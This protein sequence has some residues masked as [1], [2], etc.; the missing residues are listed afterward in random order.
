MR[1]FSCGKVIGDKWNAYLELLSRD[2]SEG[3]VIRRAALFRDFELILIFSD[4]LDELQLKRYC[5]RRMVLTHVDLIEKLLHYNRAFF[6]SG[7]ALFVDQDNAESPLQQLWSGQKTKCTSSRRFVQGTSIFRIIDSF[8]L[9]SS[10]VSSIWSVFSASPGSDEEGL[11]RL[12][13]FISRCLV[14]A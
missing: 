1:C 5:C 4:A 11:C 8:F 3:W 6:S 13:D 10:S 7:L 14:P 12:Y 2:M 9:R